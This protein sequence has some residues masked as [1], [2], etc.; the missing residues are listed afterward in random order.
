MRIGRRRR[1]DEGLGVVRQVLP[2]RR[3]TNHDGA[4]AAQRLAERVDL[5]DDGPPQLGRQRGDGASSTISQDAR[6]VRFIYDKTRPPVFQA[7]LREFEERRLVAVHRVDAL[8]E[9]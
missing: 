1:V 8:D 4:V 5:G 2:R 3:I 9:D 7:E 6:R